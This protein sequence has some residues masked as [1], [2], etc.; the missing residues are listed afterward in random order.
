MK[1]SSGKQKKRLIRAEKTIANFK[2]KIEKIVSETDDLVSG[3]EI[4]SPLE[5]HSYLQLKNE[6]LGA[7]N[8]FYRTIEYKRTAVEQDIDTERYAQACKDIVRGINQDREL[9]PS[10][11]SQQK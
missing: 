2:A 4:L 7:V 5:I 3:L 9:Q 10:P 6:A 8:E 1:E 11:S